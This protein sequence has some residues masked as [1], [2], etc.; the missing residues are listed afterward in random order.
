[1]QRELFGQLGGDVH[2]VLQPGQLGAGDTLGMAA[3]AGSDAWLP[4]LALRVNSDD[5]RN[6]K[7]EAGGEMIKKLCDLHIVVHIRISGGVGATLSKEK[8]ESR[9]KVLNL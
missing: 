3:Q 8:F 2:A 4:G 6:W 1:M 5:R 7:R 9:Y